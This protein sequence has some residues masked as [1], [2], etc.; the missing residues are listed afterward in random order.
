LSAE[1]LGILG[2]LASLAAPVVLANIAQTLMGLVDTLMVARLGTAAIA[3]VGVSTLL[4]SAVATSLKSLDVA[5]QTFIARRDGQGRSRETGAVLGTGLVMVLAAGVVAM[6]LGLRWPG[7]GI[8]LVSADA[9]VVELG[10]GYFFW[11]A[12]G[13]LPFLVFVLIRAAFDGLGR[14]GVGMVVGVGMNLLNVVLNWMLIFGK[15]GAPALGVRGAA[16]ASSL[17]ALAAMLAILPLALGPQMHRRYGWFAR[18]AVRR[19]LVRPLLRVGLPPALQAAGLI[20]GLVV[21]YGI[22]GH[23]S[24]VAVAAGNIVMR[25]ASLAIMPAIGVGVAVQ[26]LVSR[27]LGARDARGAWRYGLAG[28]ALAA[29]VMSV[30]GLPFVLLPEQVMRAFDP[31]PAVLDA[32]RGILR[33]TALVQ[34]LAAAGLTFAGV[35]RGAGDTTRVLVVDVA[36]GAGFMLPA[37]WLLGVVLGGG[38]LGTWWALAGWVAL[39][40][41]VMTRLF[42]GKRWLRYRL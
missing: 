27:C 38:L 15:L 39:H 16:L 1:R 33:I 20:G 4:F 24:T 42:A 35:L 10:T 18:G 8:G 30:L 26:T 12:A 29:G 7:F 32:G 6:A 5:V 3:A 17:A 41:V 21:F 34:I 31:S 23:I 13:L 28:V 11:R 36:T 19:D 2:R 40:A 37:A 22:L 9:E 25:T 14:T